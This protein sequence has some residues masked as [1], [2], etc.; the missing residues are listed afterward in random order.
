MHLRS[1]A[2]MALF[3]AAVAATPQPPAAGRASWISVPYIAQSWE[4]CGSA[5][6]A[7]VLQYW[8]AKLHRPDGQAADANRIQ[9]QLYSRA[10][11]GIRASSME[12]YL[13]SQGYQVF[14]FAGQWSDL[15]HHIALG[16]PLIVALQ[17]SGAHGPLHYVVV[18][19]VDA[20]RG[21]VY[22]DDPARK[23]MLRLSREGFES[24]WKGAHN[25]TLLALPQTPASLAD[26]AKPASPDGP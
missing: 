16:R 26:P 25:W 10:A 9:S 7:M 19:G 21:F 11:H 13:R 23:P 5:S 24:E 17:A 20:E 6:L 2:G 22:V 14:A 12:A 4:G 18:A 1:F 8:D 3:A 15:V